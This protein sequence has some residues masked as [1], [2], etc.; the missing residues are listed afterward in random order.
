[1]TF[2]KQWW[3]AALVRAGKTMAQTAVGMLPAA[4]TILQVDWLVV[5][6]TALLAGM[7][8]LL[9]SMAGLPEVEQ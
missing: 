8:S 9:T 6:G 1:M 2:T 5:L 3:R 7:S 4:A